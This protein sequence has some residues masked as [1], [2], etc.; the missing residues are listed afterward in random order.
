MVTMA[1]CLVAFCGEH[2][3]TS[4]FVPRPTPITNLCHILPARHELRNIV[5]CIVLDTFP[6]AVTE[7]QLTN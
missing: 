3:S 5:C 7:L 4:L 6:H 2:Q 1:G